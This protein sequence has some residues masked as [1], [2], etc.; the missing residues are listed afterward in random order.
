MPGRLRLECAADFTGIGTILGA[1][2]RRVGQATPHIKKQPVQ[3]TD[4]YGLFAFPG[5]YAAA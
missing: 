2:G 3:I 1:R 5:N 4:L